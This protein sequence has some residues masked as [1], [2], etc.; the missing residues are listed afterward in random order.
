MNSIADFAA[1]WQDTPESH[2]RMLDAFAALYEADPALKVHRE[3]V[4]ENG[5]GC[6]DRSFHALWKMLVREMPADFRF[7]EIGVYRGQTTSL[8]G[9]LSEIYKKRA[10]VVGVSPFD[11]RAMVWPFTGD[12]RPEGEC[13]DYEKAWEAWQRWVYHRPGNET[14]VRFI[15]GDSIDFKTKLHA[16]LAGPYDM[17]YLDG[18]H[19]YEY[20]RHADGEGRRV[21]RVRRRGLEPKVAGQFFLR[22]RGSK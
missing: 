1:A 6:G 17:I 11:G 20:V 7:L 10:T 3:W 21:S 12:V 14:S 22:L 8:V 13:S 5:M 19:Q 18:N 2:Q 4:E 9:M 16:S 15:K